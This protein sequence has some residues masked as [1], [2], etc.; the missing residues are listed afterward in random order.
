MCNKNCVFYAGHFVLTKCRFLTQSSLIKMLYWICENSHLPPTGPQL[1]HAIMRN[2]GGMQEFSP[3]EEFKI[4]FRT[5]LSRAEAVH[6]KVL[7]I[8]AGNIFH[9]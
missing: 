7:K 3:Y 4:Q 6:T 8:H 2:F 9:Y 1:R 5:T